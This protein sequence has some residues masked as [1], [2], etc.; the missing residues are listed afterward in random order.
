MQAEEPMRAVGRHGDAVLPP[1][2]EGR[3]VVRRPGSDHTRSRLDPAVVLSRPGH[4]DCRHDGERIGRAS[5]K[6][7]AHLRGASEGLDCDVSGHS[8][9][10]IARDLDIDR[11]AQEGS[12]VWVVAHQPDSFLHIL[13]LVVG[14]RHICSGYSQLE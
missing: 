11:D 4:E 9:E 8:T 6:Q 7:R 2:Q 13:K 12:V 5:A 14:N 3:G 10:T 1:L